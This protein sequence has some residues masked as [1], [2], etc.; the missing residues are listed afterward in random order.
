MLVVGAGPAGGEL[1]RQLACQGTDVVLIDQLADLTKAAFSSAALP[2]EALDRF[3]LPAAVVASRWSRWQLIGPGERSRQ[4]QASRPLGV[5]LD[6][7]ALRQWL[8]QECR[9]WGARVSRL[10][11]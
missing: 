9:R 11:R 6:F 3:G 4:W 7:G 5:V 1:A 8:A 2:L 10:T